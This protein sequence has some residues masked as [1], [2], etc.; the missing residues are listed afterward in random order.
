MG[1]KYISE[2]KLQELIDGVPDV[3]D[4]EETC[5]S[6]WQKVNNKMVYLEGWS[7]ACLAGTGFPLMGEGEWARKIAYIED[8]TEE[9]LPRKAKERGLKFLEGGFRETPDAENLYGVSYGIYEK[10]GNPIP[11][12]SRGLFKSLLPVL[13]E[14][15]PPLPRGLIIKWPWKK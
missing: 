11:T 10:G 6:Y 8:L 13:P 9:I 2:E 4:P 12:E 5:I 1:A 3:G 14:E 7:D 15:G